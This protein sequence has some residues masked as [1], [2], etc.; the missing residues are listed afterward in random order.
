V[1]VRSRYGQFVTRVRKKG[2]VW[3]LAWGRLL[4]REARVARR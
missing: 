1:T 4:S 3:R 2:G